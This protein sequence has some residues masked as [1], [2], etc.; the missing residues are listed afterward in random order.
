MDA[1]NEKT[2]NS[3]PK[4]TVEEVFAK[5]AE[6]QAQ[7]TENSCNS[8]HR[9]TDSVESICGSSMGEE[10]MRESLNDV[11]TVFL[12]RETSYREMIGF[13]REILDRISVKHKR[14]SK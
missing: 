3:T 11:T 14:R 5:M 6:L 2:T 13:Y 10:E 4:L 9:L 12:S 7:L 1:N 8:M